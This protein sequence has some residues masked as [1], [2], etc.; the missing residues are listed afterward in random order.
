MSEVHEKVMA[1]VVT[2]VFNVVLCICCVWQ[3]CSIEPFLSSGIS[4]GLQYWICLGDFVWRAV[5]PVHCAKSMPCVS[6]CLYSACM[7][8]HTAG[9]FWITGSW[10]FPRGSGF[11]CLTRFRVQAIEYIHPQLVHLTWD[12]PLTSDTPGPMCTAH[13]IVVVVIW[14]HVL[15]LRTHAVVNHWC[16]VL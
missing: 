12:W 15:L 9:E 16:L 13:L 7:G 3:M 4:W 2:T 10:M 14:W 5:C 1:L 8:L 6:V 11:V